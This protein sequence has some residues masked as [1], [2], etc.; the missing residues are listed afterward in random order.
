MLRYYYELKNK[1]TNCV[2]FRFDVVRKGGRKIWVYKEN[3]KVS[4]REFFVLFEISFCFYSITMIKT[5]SGSFNLSFRFFA[6]RI[7]N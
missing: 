3:F 7:L 4:K 1:T 5:K 6:M 2:E